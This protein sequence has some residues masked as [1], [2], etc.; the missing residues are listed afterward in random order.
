MSILWHDGFDMDLGHTYQYEQWAGNNQGWTYL[1]GAEGV[2]RAVRLV[3]RTTWSLPLAPAA[4]PWLQMHGYWQLVGNNGATNRQPWRLYTGGA[5][6][7]GGG[8]ERFRIQYNFSAGSISLIALGTGGFS[9][10]S[11]SGSVPGS[12]WVH[13][14]VI[15]RYGETDGEMHCW[16]N[17]VKVIEEVGVNTIGG[18]PNFWEWLALGSWDSAGTSTSNRSFDH[19]HLIVTDDDTRLGRALIVPLRPSTQGAHDDW[20]PSTGADKP[21]L[22]NNVPFNLTNWVETDANLDTDTYVHGLLP[23]AADDYPNVLGVSHQILA[24]TDD[25]NVAPVLRRGTTDEVGT[26]YDVGATVGYHQTD[27]F[28]DPFTA[29]AWTKTDIDD[30]EIGIQAQT[31]V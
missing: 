31:A 8:T 21:A 12:G 11:N 25:L 13:V 24:Q 16:A 29:A 10:T 23:A 26:Q 9:K 14:N 4:G 1:G 28:L 15:L 6:G 17:D 7:E 22:V 18:A 20:T 3:N 5:A 27:H 19:D 30:T 2:G